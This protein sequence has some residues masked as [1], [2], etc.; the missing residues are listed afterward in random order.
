MINIE[1]TYDEWNQ[2]AESDKKEYVEFIV[3]DINKK[4]NTKVDPQKIL[5]RIEERFSWGQYVKN[6][7]SKLIG[8]SIALEQRVSG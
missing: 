3:G 4:D 7:L 1:T 5:D 2:Y 8:D 6:P